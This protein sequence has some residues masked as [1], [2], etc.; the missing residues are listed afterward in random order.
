[1]SAMRRGNEPMTFHHYCLPS[2]KHEGWAEVVIGDNGFFAS[3]SDYGNYA[4]RWT[5]WGD[6][7]F[8]DFFCGLEADY[9]RCKLDPSKHF[10][11]DKT[12][13]ACRRAIGQEYK[14]GG[15]PRGRLSKYSVH[16]ALEGLK[17]VDSE[18]DFDLWIDH[19]SGYL[20]DYSEMYRTSPS[21]QILAFVTKTLPRIKAAIR[22]KKP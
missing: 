6:K 5:D 10:D 9:V 21:P 12:V 4:F 14:H 18:Y 3:V 15:N 1:M 22:E 7:S 11:L 17:D 2:V 13:A 19:W 16:E 8:L 20:D